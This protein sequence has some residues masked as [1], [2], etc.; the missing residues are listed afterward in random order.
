MHQPGLGGAPAEGGGAGT[1]VQP[2]ERGA[3]GLGAGSCARERRPANGVAGRRWMRLWCWEERIMERA[4]VRMEK[5][6]FVV[7]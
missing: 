3:P 6:R 2:A 7:N 5:E 1:L 4:A